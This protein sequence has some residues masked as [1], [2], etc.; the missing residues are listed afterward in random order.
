[1]SAAVFQTCVIFDEESSSASRCKPAKQTN[2]K[3][4]VVV[5]FFCLSADSSQD[6]VLSLCSQLWS[7]DGIKFWDENDFIAPHLDDS[8]TAVWTNAAELRQDVFDRA[9]DDSDHDARM[10][11]LRERAAQF[12][13]LRPD[14]TDHHP[15]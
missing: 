5:C 15:S 3:C 9:D 7:E 13:P 2:K 6:H 11:A 10:A 4:F 12:G 8:E 14:V 1:M